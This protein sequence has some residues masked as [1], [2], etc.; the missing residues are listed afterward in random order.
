MNATI[1]IHGDLVE[2]HCYFQRPFRIVTIFC[3]N[4]G[5]LKAVRRARKWARELG[6]ELTLKR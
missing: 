5:M 2:V 3:S 1:I 4:T 6:Y